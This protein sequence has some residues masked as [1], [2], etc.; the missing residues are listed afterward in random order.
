[1]NRHSSLPLRTYRIA[2]TLPIQVFGKEEAEVPVHMV[3]WSN[4]AE[5]PR[6]AEREDIT[7]EER[8]PLG[9]R[10]VFFFCLF[11]GQKSTAVPYF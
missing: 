8:F 5:D 7:L 3:L 6:F 10:S 4:P 11:G 9:S 2:R 1:M